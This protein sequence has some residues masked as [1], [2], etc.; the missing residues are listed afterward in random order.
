[1]RSLF[2][3]L[4]IVIS[5]TFVAVVIASCGAQPNVTNVNTTNLN[6]NSSNNLANANTAATNT[7]SN[8]S[9][10]V[11]EAAEPSEY[12]ANVAI[13]L[14]ALGNQQKTTLPTLSAKVAR[15]GT[16]RRM[17]FIMPAA[18]TWFIWTKAARTT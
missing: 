18:A 14:E 2:K 4:V 16:D 5:F 11:S 13:K 6:A 3:F 10:T 7:N 15:K 8:S 9:I 12:Q 1:M 17:E